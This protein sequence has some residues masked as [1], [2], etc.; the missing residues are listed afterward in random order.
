[1]AVPAWR[2]P[3]SPSATPILGPGPDGDR[4]GAMKDSTGFSADIAI[5]AEGFGDGLPRIV[6]EVVKPGGVSKL[7]PSNAHSPSCRGAKMADILA[8]LRRLKWFVAS[9]SRMHVPK[10]I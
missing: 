4:A 7:R 1:M 8:P 2:S 10:P 6:P 9:S 3:Q 5:D